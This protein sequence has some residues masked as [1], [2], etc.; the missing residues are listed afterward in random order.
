MRLLDRNPLVDLRAPE[1]QQRVRDLHPPASAP[2][3]APNVD[4]LP[5]A[6]IRSAVAQRTHPLRLSLKPRARRFI[7]S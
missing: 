1:K 7:Y 6:P 4:G 5:V 3:V 2:V